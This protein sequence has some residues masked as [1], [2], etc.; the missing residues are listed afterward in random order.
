MRWLT[1]LRVA[2]MEETQNLLIWL[3]TTVFNDPTIQTELQKLAVSV[4][5]QQYVR[6]LF[7]F[8]PKLGFSNLIKIGTG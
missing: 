3:F 5:S 2:A 8:V 1:A 6:V 4:L 7:L